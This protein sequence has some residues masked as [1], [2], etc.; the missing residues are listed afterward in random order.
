MTDAPTTYGFSAHHDRALSLCRQ[1]FGLCPFGCAKDGAPNCDAH[2][3]GIANVPQCEPGRVTDR[4]HAPDNFDPVQYCRF[5]L[6]NNPL[7]SRHVIYDSGEQEPRRRLKHDLPKEVW[8]AAWQSAGEIMV[9]SKEHWTR[10]GTR[11]LWTGKP[12]DYSPAVW[13]QYEKEIESNVTA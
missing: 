4:T 11:P 6:E 9:E 13:N 2:V 8:A 10:Y 5:I 1:A 3:R 7:D 12:S